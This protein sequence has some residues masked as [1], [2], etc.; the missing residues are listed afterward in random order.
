VAVAVIE[1]L[2]FKAFNPLSF[3]PK[4]EIIRPFPL[5]GRPGW[6]SKKY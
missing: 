2:I 1:M 5:G 3:S 6:G 4:G